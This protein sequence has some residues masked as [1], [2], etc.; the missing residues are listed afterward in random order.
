MLYSSYIYK[1][2]TDYI[3]RGTSKLCPLPGPLS[4]S[5]L[6]EKTHQIISLLSTCCLHYYSESLC[7]HCMATQQSK[8]TII[9]FVFLIYFLFFYLE[10]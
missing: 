9:H 2:S 8:E 5:R 3:A 7:S 1:G 4:N 6:S 10:L